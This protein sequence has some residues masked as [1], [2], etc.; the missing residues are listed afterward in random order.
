MNTAGGCRPTHTTSC[1]HFYTE[2]FMRDSCSAAA[3]LLMAQ[4]G[5]GGQGKRQSLSLGSHLKRYVPLPCLGT[6]ES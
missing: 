3:G 6:G 1:V 4:R 5:G 2:L